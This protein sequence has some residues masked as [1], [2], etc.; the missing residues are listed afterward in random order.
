MAGV[1]L[2][3]APQEVGAWDI[4]GGYVYDYPGNGPSADG[5]G[6]FPITQLTEWILQSTSLPSC[7]AACDAA[8]FPGCFGA[9]R[10]TWPRAYLGAAH[11]NG[12]FYSQLEIGHT[13]IVLTDSQG[14]R[15]EYFDL[16]NAFNPYPPYYQDYT[17]AIYSGNSHLSS[18][19]AYSGNPQVSPAHLYASQYG[20]TIVPT[21][22]GWYLAT[23]GQSV[24]VEL[25]AAA[26]PNFTS[27]AR[28]DGTYVMSYLTIG[29]TI[30]YP[31]VIRPQPLS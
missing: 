24:L 26:Q 10:T 6:F 18:F 19:V 16:V 23:P 29:C 8:R 30:A 22:Q 15:I 14:V 20:A 21:G 25:K 1:C 12:A 27:E 4:W 3:R 28:W 11:P 9:T 17:D 13:G 2:L 5:L 31:I 7:T